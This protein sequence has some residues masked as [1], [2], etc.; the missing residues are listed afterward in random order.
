MVNRITGAPVST[1]LLRGSGLI[2][3]LTTLTLIAVFAKLGMWQLD[4][5]AE[6]KSMLQASLLAGSAAPMSALPDGDLTPMRYREF[7]LRG[8]FDTDHQFLLD[9]RIRDKQ[10]GFEVMTPF[11][12]EGSGTTILVNRGWLGHDGNRNLKTRI[13]VSDVDSVVVSG[14]LTMPSKG[15]TLGASI[16]S[17]Q[18]SW[19]KIIQYADYETVATVLNVESLASAVLVLAADQ[20]WSYAYNWQPVANGP[21]K[22]YG[23]AFQWFA[24]LLAVVIIFVYLNFIKKDD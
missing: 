15:F 7:L 22:H 13:D 14:V 5:A 8:R 9:N 16:D 1:R 19:P 21:Q 20:P 24:M 2:V 6:K 10:A 23:Y 11:V 17:S 18:S 3:T 12:T 4:R